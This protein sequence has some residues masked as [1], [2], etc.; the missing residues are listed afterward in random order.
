MLP[1]T[2][3]MQPPPPPGPPPPP[4]TPGIVPP[5]PPGPP[6]PVGPPGTLPPP[7]PG[8]PPPVGPPGTLP[9]PPFDPP[10]PLGPGAPPGRVSDGAAPLEGTALDIVV[11][12]VVLGVVL[13]LGPLLSPPPQATAMTSMAPPPN[14]AK[15]VLASV[16]MT[17]KSPICHS[18]VLGHIPPIGGWKLVRS[19]NGRLSES[20]WRRVGA[21]G[22]TSDWGAAKQMIRAPCRYAVTSPQEGI[23]VT[24]PAFRNRLPGRSTNSTGPS[25]PEPIMTVVRSAGDVLSDHTVFVTNHGRV[26]EP[27][28]STRGFLVNLCSPQSRER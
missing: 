18:G 5:P 7:P 12:V 27:R 15:A 14:N 20:P 8:P 11:G 13:L 21:R 28:P 1:Q 19:E 24:G 17:P 25:E 10:V 6:P 3:P 23:R 9:P 4:P 22:G 2:L 26:N 16:L